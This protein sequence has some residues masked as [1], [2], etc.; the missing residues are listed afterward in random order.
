LQQHAVMNSTAEYL[1]PVQKKQPFQLLVQR[2]QQGFPG[3]QQK[4]WTGSFLILVFL[5]A[6]QGCSSPAPKPELGKDLA[7]IGP[8]ILHI[9]LVPQVITLD[10]QLN[11]TPLPQVTADVKDFRSKVTQV[12]LRF[13][14]IPLEMPLEPIGGTTWRAIFSTDQLQNLAVTG[15]SVRYEA[16]LVA[17]NQLGETTESNPPFVITIRAPS[18]PNR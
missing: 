1:N 11:A 15:G 5:L 7:A 9:Q 4:S 6:T 17:K 3:L 12:I 2:L 14:H 10:S 8:S 13:K 16:T 18:I